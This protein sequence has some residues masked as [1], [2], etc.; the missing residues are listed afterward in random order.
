MFD[1]ILVPL[2]GSAFA[3][4]ILPYALGLAESA[5]ARLALLRVAEDE[6]GHTAAEEYISGLGRYLDVEGK[7]AVAH[8]D[9]ARAILEELG[10]EPRTLVAMTTH[11][12]SGLMELILG[13]VA[14]GVVQRSPTPVLIYRPRGGAR[15]AKV[16]RK[17]RIATIVAPLDGSDF[18]ERMLPHAAEI[19]V[20]LKASLTL[21]QVVPEGFTG[22]PGVPAGDVVES[23]Y[24]HRVA[25]RIRAEHGVQAD[26]EVLHGEPA[27][28]ICRYL[29]GRPDAML[30][31]ASH[32][33]PGLEEAVFGSVTHEC[34]RR[35]GVPVLV[36]RPRS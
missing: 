28:A 7:V 24:V 20:I 4:E 15:P 35:A 11:G 34:V 14:L 10:Q 21:A 29:D 33:R 16:D 22:P 17:A 2:D 26:W 13:S 23:S 8:T 31:M 1:R 32:A 30:A 25:D 6:G 18:A 9:P 19:A 12:H 3:E 5:A 27:G 36:H